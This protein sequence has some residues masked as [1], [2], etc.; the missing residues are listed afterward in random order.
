MA[1]DIA[2]ASTQPPKGIAAFTFRS[3]LHVDD[4]P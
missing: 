2:D 4:P 3:N 1:Q